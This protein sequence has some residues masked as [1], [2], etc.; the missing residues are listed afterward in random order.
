MFSDKV[1]ESTVIHRAH[2]LQQAVSQAARVSVWLENVKLDFASSFHHQGL[3]RATGGGGIDAVFNQD[4][5][6]TG[7]SQIQ[8]AL[9]GAGLEGRF[10]DDVKHARLSK[11]QNNI[12]LAHQLTQ[13]LTVH[14]LDGH[15][16]VL[17]GQATLGQRGFIDIEFLHVVAL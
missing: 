3:Y 17:F 13:L 11:T 4:D 8:R 9:Q 5:G 2:A 14:H 6:I 1:D 10:V 15:E 7:L 12:L 16:Q